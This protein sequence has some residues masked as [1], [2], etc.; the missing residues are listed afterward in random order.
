MK[1]A[2]MPEKLTPIVNLCRE[3]DPELA[4]LQNGDCVDRAAAMG[5]R[6]LTGRRLGMAVF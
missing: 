5:V 1:E 4:V 2:A 3:L 6:K